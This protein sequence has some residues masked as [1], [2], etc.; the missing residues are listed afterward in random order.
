MVATSLLEGANPQDERS[1][2]NISPIADTWMHLTYLAAGGERNRV[3]YDP[4]GVVAVSTPWNA[5]LMLATWRVGPALA[6]QDVPRLAG[7]EDVCGAVAVEI[8]G[9]RR[10]TEG[11][12][13]VGLVG[14]LSAAQIAQDGDAVAGRR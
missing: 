6:P 7:D 4:C 11:G 13:Q 12:V 2:Q 5:P 1:I 14:E 8:N 10:G 9:A 3:R